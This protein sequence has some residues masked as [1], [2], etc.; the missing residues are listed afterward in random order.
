MKYHKILI[1]QNK[2][3]KRK[4]HLAP[5]ILG[6]VGNLLVILATCLG[7]VPEPFL[8]SETGGNIIWQAKDIVLISAILGLVFSGFSSFLPF[9]C[10][11]LLLLLSLVFGS[12]FLA[13]ISIFG[14]IGSG[15]VF[16]SGIFSMR[17]RKDLIST[18]R[19]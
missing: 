15:L 18:F 17:L 7:M 16:L 10:G 6:V 8:L 13:T 5:I 4:L 11:I 1:N 9:L 12:A 2:P 19:W 14:L 3:Y